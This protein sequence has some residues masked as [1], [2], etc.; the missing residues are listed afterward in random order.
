MWFVLLKARVSRFCMYI[1]H[2]LHQQ[3]NSFNYFMATF[4]F[5]FHNFRIKLREWTS[6]GSGPQLGSNS[7]FEWPVRLQ[8]HLQ[9]DV[10]VKQKC[11]KSHAP[12]HGHSWSLA[13]FHCLL[14]SRVYSVVLTAWRSFWEGLRMTKYKH[15]CLILTPKNSL[16]WQWRQPFRIWS[17]LS[18]RCGSCWLKT[19]LKRSCAQ[20]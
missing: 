4:I 10:S 12:N 5:H 1:W 15:L 18:K 9:V 14:Q 2:L 6:L 13:A 11:P 17:V 7:F 20:M 16:E 19:Q 8:W 3:A